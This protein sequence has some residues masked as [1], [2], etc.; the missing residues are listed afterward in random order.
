VIRR[1]GAKG[2]GLFAARRIRAGEAFCEQPVIVLPD[3]VADVIDRAPPLRDY[4]FNFDPSHCAYALG[5][6]A[7]MNHDGERP[8]V[9]VERDR[10]ARTLRIRATRDVAPGDE[11]LFSYTCGP[12]WE[13]PKP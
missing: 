3:E 1:A 8:N 9:T 13:Q 5:H 11:L 6:V 2:H 4:E 10:D 12:W 7:F